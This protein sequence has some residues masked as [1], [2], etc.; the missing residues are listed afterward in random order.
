[1][2]LVEWAGQ[3]SHAL[4]DKSG[5]VIGVLAGKPRDRKWDPLMKDL[6][7]QVRSARKKMTF[8]QKQRNNRRASGPSVAMGTSFGGGSQCAE[9]PPKAPGTMAFYGVANCRIL[10]KM[11]SSPSFQRLIGFTNC[12]FQ[13]FAEKIFDLYDT[14]LQSLFE[15]DPKLIRWFKKSVFSSVSFNLGPACVSWPHT[16]N[17]NLAFG[18]CAITALGQFDPDRGG[19]LILW[20]LGLIIRFPPGSTILIPSA[21]LT[22][23]NLPIQKGEERYSIIQYSSSGLFRWDFLAT[24]KREE[25]EKR[26]KDK[27]TRWGNGLKMFSLWNDIC[28]RYTST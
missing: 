4:A 24:R 5:R 13:C 11:T 9:V 22:H 14:T 26:E 10:T 25:I 28:S 3:E 1:M 21:L 23:S 8:S 15:S 2:Q 16:D 7:E 18:W 20:D 27:K 19:H 12:V 6:E 17:Y